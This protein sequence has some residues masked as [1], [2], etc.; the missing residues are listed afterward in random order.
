MRTFLFAVVLSVV[1]ISVSAAVSH[2][3]AQVDKVSATHFMNNPMVLLT[4]SGG[5]GDCANALI[6]ISFGSAPGLDATGRHSSV[7]RALSILLAAK[8]TGSTVDISGPACVNIDQI[9][10][11]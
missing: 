5:T 6:F 2:V 11:N 7:D 1:S 4:M 10:I 8:A 3:D 9:T